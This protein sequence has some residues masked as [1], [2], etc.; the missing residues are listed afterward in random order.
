[1]GNG[2][3][4]VC[5]FGV[6]FWHVFLQSPAHD[7]DDKKMKERSDRKRTS[8]V[9]DAAKHNFCRHFVIAV[10]CLTPLFAVCFQGEEDTFESKRHKGEGECNAHFCCHFLRILLQQVHNIKPTVL[11]SDRSNSKSAV[12][13]DTAHSK[14]RG[15]PRSPAP[16]EHRRSGASAYREDADD[17]DL[18]KSRRVKV[19]VRVDE[20]RRRCIRVCSVHNF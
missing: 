6:Q 13:G 8:V 17:D 11:L 9:S 4:S 2:N 3:V 1:M 10:W 14:S 15:R 20:E 19:S 16:K 7:R 12:N 5:S 18:K